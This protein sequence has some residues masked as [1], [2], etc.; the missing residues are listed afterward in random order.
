MI[1]ST[2]KINKLEQID[3][4]V[5][6]IN[7]YSNLIIGYSFNVNH[8]SPNKNNHLES[9]KKAHLMSTN[10]HLIWHLI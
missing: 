9:Q 10:R 1:K 8:N 5:F 4:G 2:K 3:F 7:L 6:L